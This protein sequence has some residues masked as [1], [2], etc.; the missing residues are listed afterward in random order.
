MSQ[1]AAASHIM[2]DTNGNDVKKNIARPRARTAKGLT[3]SL[4][5]AVPDPLVDDISAVD[6]D[7][8]SPDQALEL[9]RRWKKMVD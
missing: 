7:S 3:A 9:I 2:P 4:F 5:A 1:A 8:I 6:L